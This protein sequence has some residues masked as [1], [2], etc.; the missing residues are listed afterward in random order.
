MK[1][2]AKGWRWEAVRVTGVE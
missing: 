1:Q 2:E